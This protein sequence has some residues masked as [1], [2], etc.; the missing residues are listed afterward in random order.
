LANFLTGGGID[1]QAEIGHFRL[2]RG[3]KQDVSGFYITMRYV[4][5]VAVRKRIDYFARNVTKAIDR[6]AVAF[7][8]L[9]VEGTA[10]AVFKDKE[11]LATDLEMV[12]ESDYT[13]MIE[14]E[15]GLD[16]AFEKFAHFLGFGDVNGHNF[17]NKFGSPFSLLNQVDLA[18]T[19][20]ADDL[21]EEVI[22]NNAR[23]RGRFQ[24]GWGVCDRSERLFPH[25]EHGRPLGATG[26]DDQ[27][28]RRAFFGLDP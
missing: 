28:N 15:K 10:G 2:S 27:K 13:G 8:D 18:E 25:G 1:A 22:A 6:Q 5:G 20:V 9:I 24:D 19:A 3:A 23:K 12:V 16:F 11:K 4:L 21:L 14:A 17:G 26:S 7:Y